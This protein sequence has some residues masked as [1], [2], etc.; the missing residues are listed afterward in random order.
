MFDEIR[1]NTIERLP[2]YVFAQINEQKMALRR[3]GKDI[4]DFS[5]GNPDGDTPKHITNK[6]IQTALR[7]KTQ[8]YSASKGIYKL[9]LAICDW[10]KRRYGIS[11]DPE[12]EAVATMGSKEGYVHLVQAITNPGDVAVVPEPAYPIHTHAFII[13]G[14]N[15]IK[16]P[17][18]FNDAYD[19]MKISFSQISAQHLT[20]PCLALNLSS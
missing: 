14:G 2:N 1:F 11:L 6:L 10:Y 4:I 20:P 8:G 9:R 5:M 3:E 16:M 18:E 7:S 19:L 12:K 15:V 17:L 13:A